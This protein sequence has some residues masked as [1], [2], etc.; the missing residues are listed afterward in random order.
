MKTTSL[1]LRLMLSL[2]FFAFSI[3]VQAVPMPSPSVKNNALS[4]IENKGQIM[5]Q[6]QQPRADI[7]FRMGGNGVNLFV[8]AAA[9]HYQ[10]VRATDTRVVDRDTLQ[11][12]VLYRMDVQL[13]GANPNAQ[14]VRDQKQGYYE[15]YY[16][17]A[18]GQQGAIAHSYH[19]IT[20]KEVYPDIDW[21]LYVSGN[22]VE[23][24]FVVRPGG[25]VA[26]I[27][28]QYSGATQLNV[29]N[30][31]SLTATTP[32]GSVT[33][34]APVAFQQ[35]DNKPVASSFSLDNNVLSFLAGDYKGTLVIDPVLE[36]GTYYGGLGDDRTTA[37]ETDAAG[38]V[39]IG[40][41][42][43]SL[44]NMVTSG[45]FQEI[46]GGAS[47]TVAMGDAFIAKF[48]EAGNCLW[49]TYYGGELEDRGIDLA[50]DEVTS[51]LYLAGATKS[52]AGIATPTGHQA[53]HGGDLDAFIAKFD[54]SGER[55]WASY[56]GGSDAEGL[57]Y[58]IGVCSDPNGNVFL[59]GETSSTDNIATP[60]AYQLTKNSGRD[61]FVA[62]FDSSGTRQWGT[63][64]GGEGHDDGMKIS[65]DANGNAY[66]VGNTSST[67][68][69]A[70]PGSQQ[71]EYS[72]DTDGFV[73]KLDGA[74]TMQ[75]ST[76][77]GSTGFESMN[78]MTTE[79]SGTIYIT[80]TTT[81]INNLSTTGSFQTAYGGGPTD[82][83]FAKYDADG[84]LAWASYLG[85][86]DIDEAQSVVVDG[87]GNFYLSGYT[88]SPTGFATP[89]A[90]MDTLY[91]GTSES[92]I[93]KFDP[94]AQQ[95]WGTY[96]GGSGYEIGGLIALSD[97]QNLYLAGIT[98]SAAGIASGS[99]YQA[100]YGGGASDVFLTK[101]NACEAPQ[102]PETINGDDTLC[103][104]QE[105]TYSVDSVPGAVSYTWIL[106]EGWIG[107]SDSDSIQV[108]PDQHS[109]TLSV[110]A[111][112]SCASSDTISIDI[113]V[114][115][116][117][118]PEIVQNENVLST[119]ESYSSY[120]WFF[121]EEAIA[122]ATAANYTLSEEGTYA[123]QVTNEAGCMGM[124]ESLT[125]GPVGI[126][127]MNGI[128]AAIKVYPN[129]ASTIVFIDASVAV[130]ATISSLD[131]RVWIQEVDKQT[132]DLSFLA[133]G[134]YWI[135][136][137][138]RNDRLLKVVPIVKLQP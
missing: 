90:Y 17:P 39:Y 40:G 37:I 108:T 14:V 84:Q 73:F 16:T 96:I 91:N 25:R 122:G 50:L 80:G 34:A 52:T 63:Y 124:S 102:Q 6:F 136:I 56:Y 132:I 12:F 44:D 30:D 71:S 67:Q 58:G 70:T 38:N 127:E 94:N 128:A 51:H 29:N 135:R 11:E 75:W 115:L 21:V 60:G 99:A 93:V 45:A 121:N 1:H 130:K 13:L 123:V 28:L 68:N 18:F 33:E 5:D 131:G 76:Y 111:H 92:Y 137:F 65:S 120:Q 61:A 55:V 114:E 77:I 22:K 4:F 107:E 86:A 125:T 3:S 88:I 57:V 59:V 116:S 101:M 20:Y 117:P 85:G 110:V 104:G 8:G 42:T 95:T 79:P 9:L 83:F 72:G 119:A 27:K 89:D 112:N 69:I 10:W 47:G 35:A 81:S 133:N 54:L 23:Y 2:L 64:L 118:E 74:G 78:A 43:T 82:G 36:W 109:G 32:M 48:D 134:N 126:E 138:D 113:T 103:S 87:M 97:N 15:R 26:D 49:A 105:H 66:I 31:G 41:G 46:Y 106:P 98:T 53:Q 100:N 19:K 7:D 62:K 24:D 129:P